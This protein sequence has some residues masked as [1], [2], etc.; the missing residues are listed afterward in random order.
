MSPEQPSVQAAESLL[1]ERYAPLALALSG[2]RLQFAQA[3]E[4]ERTHTDG[5]IVYLARTAA[6]ADRAIEIAVQCALL[7]AGSLAPRYILSVLGRPQRAR[8]YLALETARV[9]HSASLLTRL[10]IRERLQLSALVAETTEE[11]LRLAQDPRVDVPDEPLLGELRPSRLLARTG[12]LALGAARPEDLRKAQQPATPDTPEL[13]DD[14]EAEDMPSLLDKFAPPFNVFSPMADLLRKLLGARRG[15]S[16]QAP[17]MEV[18]TGS[19]RPALAPSPRG[20]RAAYSIEWNEAESPARLISRWVYPEWDC[21]KQQY[22]AEWCVV[23]EVPAVWTTDRAEAAPFHRDPLLEAGL[24][25][26]ALAMARERRQLDGDDL[27]L[28]AA[29]DLA[30]RQESNRRRGASDEARAAIYSELQRTRRDL[31]A[32][33]LL[34][35]SGSSAERMGGG[36]SVLA[37]QL[38]TAAALTQALHSV[39]DRVAAL[40]FHSRGRDCVRAILLKSFDDADTHRAIRDMLSLKASGY[41]RLG[42]GI[43]HAT[44]R[45]AHDSGVERRLLVVISDGVPYDDGYSGHYGC[46]DVLCAL[47]ECADQQVRV[48]W[49]SFGA[50]ADELRAGLEQGSHTLV[51]ADNYQ[52]LRRR[53]AGVI[54]QALVTQRR[55]LPRRA[56][57]KSGLPRLH[58]TVA[59]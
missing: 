47:E 35:V 18:P 4:G 27:D 42:A 36:K 3:R 21:L 30:V 20:Q 40:A 46:R 34:D 43:R 57:R 48:L 49:L 53:L 26:L 19:V 17:G 38:Q 13:D 1:T 32:L 5:E 31:A 54:A 41:T 22:R 39:G 44:H 59:Q 37:E 29:V 33:V 51:L 28:D 45:L 2:R 15:A 55:S 7:A 11:S 8:R 12:P 56:F 6:D 10:V 14:E 23:H 52:A 9:L 16:A 58:G 25:R 50:M 24:R